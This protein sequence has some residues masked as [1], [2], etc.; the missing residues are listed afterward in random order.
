MNMQGAK[1]GIVGAGLIG[2]GWAAFY[3]SRGF[4][5]SLFDGDQ[6]VLRSAR[7]RTLAHLTF[8]HKHGL[9]AENDLDLVSERVIRASDLDEAVADTYLVQE[10]VVERYDVKKQVFRAVDRATNPRTIVASSSSGLLMSELQAEMEHPER[11]LIAHPFNPPHLMPLVELVP[12][13][14]TRPELVTEMRTW[15]ESL[16]KVP[17]VVKTEVPGHV[18][19]R[20]QA[21]VWREAIDLVLRGVV[22]VSDV[23]KALVAGPGLRWALMGAHLCFH[24]GGGTG[25]IEYF[26]DHVGRSFEAL[27]SDM[28]SWDSLPAET[29]E[30]LRTGLAVETGNRQIDELVRWRDEKIVQILKVSRET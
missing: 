6:A 16:G 21:A 4:A 27:W 12:G 15:F 3:A 11:A 29:A 26:I 24:L 22:S 17:I 14:R 30:A 13:E 5:V 2:T 25:G 19:N 10:S 20:L 9:L 1:I 8:L 23:D 28:A 18:A 7:D